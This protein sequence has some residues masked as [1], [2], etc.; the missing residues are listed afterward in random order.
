MH[1]TLITKL[2]R[3]F[4]TLGVI[5]LFV[6]LV[7]GHV[8][9]HAWPTSKKVLYGSSSVIDSLWIYPPRQIQWTDGLYETYFVTFTG[10]VDED[11]YRYAYVRKDDK[12]PLWLS[13][14]VYRAHGVW[15]SMKIYLLE[16]G[17]NVYV[18]VDAKGRHPLDSF[19]I[20]HWLYPNRARVRAPATN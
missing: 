19:Y 18:I 14:E 12:Y 4:T 15:S 3:N 17:S 1:E 13:G 5:G 10:D 9:A 8:P 20:G 11:C 6:S 16:W 7:L 2:R